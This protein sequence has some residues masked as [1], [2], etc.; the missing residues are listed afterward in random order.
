MDNIKVTYIPLILSIFTEILVFIAKKM[1]YGF[2]YL[3]MK[4]KKN[5]LSA[6][7]VVQFSWDE[8][9]NFFASYVSKTLK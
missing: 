9:L 2:Y 4:M 5:A 3:Q 1:Q 7:I 6:I 8:N